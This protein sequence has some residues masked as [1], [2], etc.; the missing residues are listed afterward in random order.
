[1]NYDDPQQS[2]CLQEEKSFDIPQLIDTI[3]KTIN[4]N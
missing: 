4:N 2:E 1:M 3:V